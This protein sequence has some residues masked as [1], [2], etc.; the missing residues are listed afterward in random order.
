MS[1]G[2]PAK[3][4]VRVVREA[5]SEEQSRK[6]HME[7]GWYEWVLREFLRYMYAVGLL[8]LLTMG[9]LQMAATW[10]PYESVP[11]VDPVVVG[12][13][14]IAFIMVVMYAGVQGYLYLWRK[15]GWV[16]RA[17]EAH[18]AAAPGRKG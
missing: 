18:G 2:T 1:E 15:G 10:L 6:R 16:D 3:R 7:P 8:A 17:V 12:F 5:L 13:V 14:A 4:V 9:P 11:L